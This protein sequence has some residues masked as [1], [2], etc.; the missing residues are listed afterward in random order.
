MGFDRRVPASLLPWQCGEYALAVADL[1][2]AHHRLADNLEDYAVAM[3]ATERRRAVEITAA[4][5]QQTS[6]RTAPGF[7]VTK[8]RQHG[9]CETAARAGCQPV[10]DAAAGRASIAAEDSAVK[11]RTSQSSHRIRREVSR[12]MPCRK[13]TISS[14]ISL[15]F[16]SFDP[17]PNISG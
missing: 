10:Y 12:T 7:A 14:Q 8:A 17:A 1:P 5:H 11:S 4:V 3:R 15:I 13:R 6:Q 9:L 2:F 16:V